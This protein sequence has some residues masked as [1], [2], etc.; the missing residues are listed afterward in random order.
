MIHDNAKRHT[1]RE[2]QLTILQIEL[3]VLLFPPYSPDIAPTDYYLFRLLKN[4]LNENTF[5]NDEKVK[6]S[7]DYK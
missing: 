6:K 4:A 7:R 3:P 5:T 2:T 1:A